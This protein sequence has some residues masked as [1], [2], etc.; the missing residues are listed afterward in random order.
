MA[1]E[2]EQLKLGLVGSRTGAVDVPVWNGPVYVVITNGDPVEKSHT[3]S[4]HEYPRNNNP[5]VVDSNTCY[6]C[7][8]EPKYLIIKYVQILYSII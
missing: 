3:T 5:I 6:T 4:D 7:I 2:A 8:A 1:L